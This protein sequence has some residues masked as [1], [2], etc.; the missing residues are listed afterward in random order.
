MIRLIFGSTLIAVF[1]IWAVYKLF[2]DKNT[3]E[4]DKTDIKLGSV[5]AV[6]FC[7]V[8]YYLLLR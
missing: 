6:I 7:V 4:K 1:V 5:F 3:T 8:F 2:F